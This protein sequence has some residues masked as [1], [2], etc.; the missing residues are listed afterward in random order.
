MSCKHQGFS[1]P[2]DE[3]KLATSKLESGELIR[4]LQLSTEGVQRYQGTQPAWAARFRV[5]E[6]QVLIW[7][8]NAKQ[9]LALLNDPLPDSSFSDT[10]V[11]RKLIQVTAHFS[12][13]QFDQ[14]AAD[15]SQAAQL[16][17]SKQPDLLADVVAAQGTLALK[18]GH[19][20]N[21]KTSYET[22]LRMARQ[23]HRVFLETSIL[24][25]L[26]VLALREQNCGE[27][28]DRF[29]AAQA[30]A[31]QLKNQT[32][33]SRL[34]VNLGWC[35]YTLGDYDRALDYY[36][37][38]QQV[39]IQLGV[40][41]D[42]I[43]CTNNIGLIS[44]TRR[45]YP[46]AVDSY[47]KSL[48]MARSLGDRSASVIALNNLSL[49]AL[50]TGNLE[51]A[52]KDNEE[53]FRLQKESGDNSWRLDSLMNAGRIAAGRK[54][55]PQSTKLFE[56]IIKESGTDLSL[57]WEAE[58]NLATV[59]AAEGKDSMAEA[60]YRRA[61]ATVDKARA[62]LSIEEHR[63]SFLNTATRFYN[64]YI[65]FLV[66]HHREREALAVAEHSRA[67]TLAEGLK[68][69][70]QLREAAFHPEENARRLNSVVLSY[71]LK[72]ERSYLWVVTPSRVQLL[73]LPSES[74]IDATVDEYRKALLGP[75]QAR[76]S[77][78]GEK[79][80]QMLV[81]PAEVL[82]GTNRSG[83]VPHVK[84]RSQAAS[85]TRVAQA[86][87]SR[88]GAVPRVIV[89]ADG[90][91]VNLNF[92][93]LIV[94]NPQPHY[95]IEDA[96]ISNASSI[97]LLRASTRNG[98]TAPSP[99]GTISHKLLLIGAPDY[100]GTEFPELSQARTEVNK[101][102]AYFPADERTVIEGKSAVPSAYDQ[103]QPGEFTYIH[104]VAHGTASRLSPLDSTIV[105]S[106]KGDAYK[107]YARDIMQQRLNADLVTISACYGAGNRAYS[108]EGLVGLSWAFLRAGAHNVIAALWEVNDAS[109]PLLMDDLYKNIKNGKDPA[110]ALRQAKL[111]MLHS[112]NVYRRPFYWGA[113]Q[114][115][116]GS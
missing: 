20:E 99:T 65:D 4:C 40:V 18:Q 53:S 72:P 79:L 62:A 113:F 55:Y 54:Q 75:S 66:A 90:S 89:I 42:Q 26:G 5:L 22:A 34:L 105:L 48:S 70:V 2:A 63:L 61:L 47:Q 110:T 59:Y 16:A 45:D 107:L 21:A 37:Q 9:A 71:W 100:T 109:T 50:A 29:A 77:A 108:G 114:L 97:A 1:R 19:R 98:T 111:D 25:N 112:D 85:L 116:V 51:L 68:I 95:W 44:Y 91:L 80:Y 10:I 14:A 87:D 102:E 106:R 96:I 52:D 11:R 83:D 94:P 3:Y 8:G 78:A 57:R 24:G 32:I 30:G 13:Q 28:I 39:S 76:D 88:S 12:L 104:F 23:Q 93:T 73:P 84:A 60:Q 82:I 103:A 115:Y 92:E 27:A 15:L 41:Q 31:T 6:A 49:A 33:A 36:T 67:R 46:R 38:A 81:S 86:R 56:E 17:E 58:S 69:P 64:A 74:E 101:V 35:Y 43:I 7:Q